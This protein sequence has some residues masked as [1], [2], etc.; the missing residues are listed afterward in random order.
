[1]NNKNMQTIVEPVDA[2]N[3]RLL[4]AARD[5]G[6]TNSGGNRQDVVES[7]LLKAIEQLSKSNQSIGA[8][9]LA[10][11]LPPAREITVRIPLKRDDGRLSIVEGYRVQH[12]DARGPFKGGLRYHQS[13]DINESRTLARLMSLKTAVVDIPFGGSKGGIKVDPAKLSLRELE[14]LTRKFA[15][16]LGDNIGPQSDIPGPDVNTNA[17]IM[18][19]IADEYSRSHGLTEA[20]VTGK[21]VDRGG[22]FGRDEATG[23]GLVL[24]IKE[25]AREKGIDLASLRVIFQGFG[26]LA[27][28]AAKLVSSELGAKVVGLSTSKGGIY[29]ARGIDVAAAQNYYRDHGKLEG[30]PGAEWMTNAQ[31]MIADCDILVPAAMEKAI[32]PEIART[33]KASMVVE[34]AN[35]STDIEADEI[36]NERGIFVVPDI[37]ANAGGVVV[38][39]FEW[40]QNL[41]RECWMLERVREELER[42]MVLA[43]QQVKKVS[44]EQDISRRLAAY[45]LAVERIALAMIERSN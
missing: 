37:L 27:S 5:D 34:G 6:A 40:K 35:D 19:W 8:D 38:S 7:Y 9:L 3:D 30:L 1:M 26:N 2:G 44:L 13:L 11:I 28:H 10:S 43:Y 42:V 15:Q 41:A 17:Q 16:L 31:L 24:I 45:T 33:M 29:N 18:A 22:S 14:V 23:R 25:A 36:L 39:Y 4:E 21:P 20:V 32:T 12:N